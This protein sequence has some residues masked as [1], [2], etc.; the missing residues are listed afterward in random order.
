M[1]ETAIKMGV[2]VIVSTLRLVVALPLLTTAN[3]NN[4]KNLYWLSAQFFC[5]VIALPFA[6]VGTLDN[7]WIF[8][9][10]ISLSEI[11]LI[12]FIHTTF[13]RGRS[14]PLPVI[15]G[16]AIAGMLGGLYGNATGNF[17]LSAW[18]V[19][20]IAILTWGWH[21]VASY[22]GY[23]S[24]ANDLETEYWVK[25]RYKLML[26]YSALDFVSAIMGTLSTTGL[27]VSN[28]GSLIVVAVNFASVITQILTWVMPEPFRN[29]LNRNQKAHAEGLIHDRAQAIMKV[30]GTAMAE[31][32]TPMVYLYAIRSTVGKLIG[33]DDNVTIE[34]HLATMG[35]AEWDQLLQRA[36]LHEFIQKTGT[37]QADHIIANARQALIKK[38]SLFT[39]RAK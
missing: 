37:A 14:S 29:W 39:M 16:L 23:Q 25:S 7:P 31:G 33:T 32:G 1:D 19:Y 4:L 17:Q 34:K 21:F 12:I 2:L 9:T 3:R 18:S 13:Y 26:T 27:W 8:W 10:F 24:I 6:A 36:D 28:F 35:Y 5:L 15:M 20:P 22:R 11:A 30:I 38:Q